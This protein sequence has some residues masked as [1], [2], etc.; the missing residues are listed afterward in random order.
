MRINK[1]LYESDL[2]RIHHISKNYVTVTTVPR[3]NIQDIEAR[4]RE[5]TAN[6]VDETAIK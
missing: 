3:I 1:G 6:M 2:A 5:E 4:M